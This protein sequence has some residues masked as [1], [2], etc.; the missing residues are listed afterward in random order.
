MPPLRTTRRPSAVVAVAGERGPQRVDLGRRDRGPVA[1]DVLDLPAADLSPDV[2][3]KPAARMARPQRGALVRVAEQGL[4]LREEQLC[5]AHVLAGAG[6]AVGHRDDG[7]RWRRSA[8]RRIALAAHHLRKV[9]QR[10]SRV[11]AERSG[12][13]IGPGEDFLAGCCACCL[14]FGSVTKAHVDSTPIAPT[15]THVITDVLTPTLVPRVP[16]RPASRGL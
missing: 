8:L 7:I 5:L 15:R 11:P 2:H 16:A 4:L 9:V 13:P 10:R 14:T 3:E 1:P 6:V 12:P